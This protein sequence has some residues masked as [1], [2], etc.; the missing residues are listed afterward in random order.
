MKL[1]EELFEMASEY[2]P[3]KSEPMPKSSAI[4]APSSSS[5]CM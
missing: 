1:K 4:S 5:S 2:S 3:S